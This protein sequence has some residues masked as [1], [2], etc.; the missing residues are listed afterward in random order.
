LRFIDGQQQ[1]LFEGLLT[2][3]NLYQGAEESDPNRALP[4]ATNPGPRPMDMGATSAPQGGLAPDVDVRETRNAA[5]ETGPAD[6]GLSKHVHAADALKGLI[7]LGDAPSC[8][9]C[10][11]IMT[12]NGS[13]YRCGECG[14]TSGCS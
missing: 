8:H 10:G 14:S 3:S 9:V 1:T 13:C 11:A 12:R 7:D 2:K 4:P 6:R 5:T